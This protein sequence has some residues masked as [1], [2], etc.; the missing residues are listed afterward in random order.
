MKKIIPL[1]MLA[2]SA[3]FAVK[4]GVMAPFGGTVCRSYGGEYLAIILD[5]EDSKNKSSVTGDPYPIGFRLADGNAYFSLCKMDDWYLKKVPYDYVYSVWIMRA[6][7][8]GLSLGA[9]MIRRMIAIKMAL[10]TVAP[11]PLS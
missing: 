4:I 1:I 2:V 8:V 5:M 7:V 9:I 11:R 6:P 10:C 3:S